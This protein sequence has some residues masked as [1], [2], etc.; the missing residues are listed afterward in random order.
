ME[1]ENCLRLLECQ[2]SPHSTS[3]PQT[4][5]LATPVSGQITHHQEQAAYVYHCMRHLPAFPITHIGFSVHYA[6][7][8]LDIPGVG[9]NMFQKTLACR[10]GARLIRDAHADSR[11]VFV[12]TVNSE[13]WM[14]WSI[15]AGVDGVITDDP[16]LF[17]EVCDRWEDDVDAAGGKTPAQRGSPLR[18]L[19]WQA[20]LAAVYAVSTLAF[21]IFWMAGRF[22]MPPPP[23]KV[24]KVLHA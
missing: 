2:F 7:R 22:K 21:V 17:L 23:I 20:D 12:W 6:R 24:R 10:S 5:G 3:C 8:F 18:K 4:L 15:R 19:L 13:H 11:T 14:E 1:R 16:K 9:F